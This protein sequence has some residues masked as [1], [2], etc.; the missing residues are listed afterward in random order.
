MVGNGEFLKRKKGEEKEQIKEESKE[1]RTEGWKE[2][3][4][5][6]ERV[7]GRRE[8]KKNEKGE[9]IWRKGRTKKAKRNEGRG[10]QN[11]KGGREERSVL[12]IVNDHGAMLMMSWKAFFVLFMSKWKD[13]CFLL[14]W[15]PN[16]TRPLVLISWD[17][18]T[19]LSLI[20]HFLTSVWSLCFH[21]WN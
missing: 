13:T 20:L 6:K 14:I 17:I 15:Q 8:E 7:K 11:K 18:F 9:E 2:G 19:E 5:D 10:R 12:C 3:W 1:G 16:P 21:S 4:E